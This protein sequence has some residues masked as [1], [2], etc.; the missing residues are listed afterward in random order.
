M[1]R[2]VNRRLMDILEERTGAYLARFGEVVR[3]S[4]TNGLHADIAI[5]DVA[6]AYNTVWHH[7]VLQQLAN[8]STSGNMGHFLSDYLSNRTFRV[9]IGGA[10]SNAFS[11]ATG[12]PRDQSSP[13]HCSLCP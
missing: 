8:W 13:S 7:G 11:K 5:L 1:E 10:Q 2:M 4:V 6:K 3:Q 9:G 12:S